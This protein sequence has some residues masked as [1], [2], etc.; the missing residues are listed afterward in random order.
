MPSGG[1]RP[2]GRPGAKAGRNKACP[3]GL[4][5]KYKKCCGAY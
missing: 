1:A 3:C 5:R 4:G 2:S